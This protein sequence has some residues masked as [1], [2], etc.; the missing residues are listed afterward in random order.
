MVSFFWL[1]KRK[2]LASRARAT[3]HHAMLFYSFIIFLNYLLHFVVN[4]VVSHIMKLN[5]ILEDAQLAP[6]KSSIE[7]HKEAILIL[8]SKKF[9]WREIADFLV[10]RGVQTD[11]TQVYR[12]ISKTKENRSELMSFPNADDYKNALT[13]LSITPNQKLMLK[14]HYEALNRS[15]TYSQL[16]EAA[17]SDKHTDA[18]RDYGKLGRII[19]DALNFEFFIKKDGVP[20]TS[21][22]IG[23]EN[24]YTKGD[25]QLVMHHELAKAIESLGWFKAG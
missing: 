12:L 25:F 8:R 3:Y 5:N 22:S 13:E 17:N 19:G 9:T 1:C 11:H 23:M 7:E 4:N 21:S 20:F 15:I 2:K 14:A 10:Q 18:N 16:A 6:S 24:T